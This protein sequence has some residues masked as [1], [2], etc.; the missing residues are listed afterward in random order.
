MNPIQIK[1]LIKYYLSKM[2][3]F[4]TVII[5]AVFIAIIY[6]V[7]IK[8][9]MYKSSTTLALTS[10]NQG[11][12]T[13]LQEESDNEETEDINT[14]EENY[15]TEMTELQQYEYN[16]YILADYCKIAKTDKLLEAVKEELDLDDTIN[17]LKS[18]ISVTEVEST[19][20]MEI[21]AVYENAEIAKN[22]V[23][24]ISE[25]LKEESKKIYAVNNIYDLEEAKIA[26]E[27]YNAGIIKNILVGATVGFLIAFIIVTL[28]YYFNDKEDEF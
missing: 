8:V 19:N 12:N 16:S 21:K 4:I 2:L 22:I 27:P 28:M 10:L 7:K 14:I 20:M 15:T 25:K 6:A 3:V 17:E 1:K 13:T 5:I 23:E 26:D 11:K 9:P 24:K 18:K